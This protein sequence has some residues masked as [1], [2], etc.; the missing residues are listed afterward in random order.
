MADRDEDL[1]TALVLQLQSA[2]SQQSS[3]L[4]ICIYLHTTWGNIPDK[5]E[6]SHFRV[7]QIQVVHLQHDLPHHVVTA[8]AVEAQDHEVQSENLHTED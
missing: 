4:Q 7:L 8:V 6:R 3:H 2:D 5:R 1:T